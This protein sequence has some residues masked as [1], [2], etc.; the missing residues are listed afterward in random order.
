MIL[1]KFYITKHIQWSGGGRNYFSVAQPLFFFL[2][3]QELLS[4]N[5]N[6]EGLTRI[7]FGFTV[8]YFRVHFR[9]DW[10]LFKGRGRVWNYN[11]NSESP[12]V[13]ITSE[14]RQFSLWIWSVKWIP[15]RGIHR[16]GRAIHQGVR[17]RNAAEMLLLGDAL[18]T[19][20]P[21]DCGCHQGPSLPQP[22]QP[23]AALTAQSLPLILVPTPGTRCVLDHWK[24]WIN[25]LRASIKLQKW[26]LYGLHSAWQES[27][28]ALLKQPHCPLPAATRSKK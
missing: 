19:P 22:K 18:G 4:M 23:R 8:F 1:V 16:K 27:H 15:V 11:P 21:L 3:H 12:V 6:L 26:Q 24:P 5:E 25:T 10:L 28:L 13:G 14:L 17:C 7:S 9:E 2:H 20:Q